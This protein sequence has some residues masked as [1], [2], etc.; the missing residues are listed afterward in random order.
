MS[1]QYT[2]HGYRVYA[3]ITARC[4][5]TVTVQSALGS[6]RCVWLL[7]QDG[8]VRA[9]SLAKLT[10]EQAHALAMALLEFAESRS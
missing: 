7:T 3:E 4:G 8:D 5:S 2:E 1:E 6:E 10:A 9:A